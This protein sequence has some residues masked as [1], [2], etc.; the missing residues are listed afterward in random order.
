MNDLPWEDDQKELNKL[1]SKS[2]MGYVYHAENPVPTKTNYYGL[3]PDCEQKDHC[4]TLVQHVD[5]T[6]V[7][8]RYHIYDI[9]HF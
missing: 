1:V 7:W 2:P 4:F 8:V 5:G 6:G 3:K 9:R